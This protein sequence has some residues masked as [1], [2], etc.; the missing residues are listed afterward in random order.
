[1][2]VKDFLTDEER[3]KKEEQEK[4]RA[5]AAKHI[6]TPDK[7]ALM[8]EYETYKL[9]WMMENELS[10]LDFITSVVAFA[11]EQNRAEELNSEDIYQLVNDWEESVGF[12]GNIYVSFEEY[13]ESYMDELYEE[14]VYEEEIKAKKSPETKMTNYEKLTAEVKA[15]FANT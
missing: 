7:D 6:S 1:M 15:L 5:E 9:D 3:R 11:E 14:A 4:L 10:L 8:L 12:G 2:N 13:E